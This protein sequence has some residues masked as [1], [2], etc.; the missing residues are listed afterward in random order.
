MDDCLPP[1]P[2]GVLLNCIPAKLLTFLPC[3]ALKTSQE[4]S[5]C[6]GF[7]LEQNKK[8]SNF[9]RKPIGQQAPGLWR[10][11]SAIVYLCATFVFSVIGVLFVIMA[12]FSCNTGLDMP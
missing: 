10:D 5:S 2:G 3:S 7:R 8:S 12:V 1:S 4:N 11:R 6:C 9:A